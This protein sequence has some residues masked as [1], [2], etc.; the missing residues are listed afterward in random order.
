MTCSS[1]LTKSEPPTTP[2]TTFLRSARSSAVISGVTVCDV[3]IGLRG[4]RRAMRNATYF[5]SETQCA[6]HIEE[7]ELLLRAIGK[8][9][10][11]HGEGATGESVER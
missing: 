8:C 1:T 10:G 5:T 9:G 3:E 7:D 2:I 6:V 11:D 4:E